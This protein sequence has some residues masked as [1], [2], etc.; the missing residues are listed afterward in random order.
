MRIYLWI[1]LI[2]LNLC[3][4]FPV[5]AQGNSVADSKPTDTSEITN[6]EEQASP[7]KPVRLSGSVPR[8]RITQDAQRS[9]ELMTEHLPK[10]S[11]LWL[12]AGSESFLSVWQRDR[13]GN[14]KGALLI[15]HAEG[16]S[17][18]WP[19]TTLRLHNT[20]PDHGWMTLAISLPTPDVQK[21]PARTLPVKIRARPLEAEVSNAGKGEIKPQAELITEST[22]HTA[23]GSVSTPIPAPDRK[24]STAVMIEKRLEAA[25][26]FLHKKGHF[27]IIILGGGSNAIYAQQFI[28]S[29]TPKIDNPKL[30]ATIQK[31]IRALIILNGL[32][33][34][35]DM[36]REFQQWFNDP[37]I[38]VLDIFTKTNQRSVLAS[39]QRK[40]LARLKKLKLYK[41]VGLHEMSFS[42]SWK[43]NAMSRRILGFLENNAAG[44]EIQSPRF[45]QNNK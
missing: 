2:Y 25:V 8:A 10:D 5:L 19:H 12:K 27:N 42:G 45:R 36:D 21:I 41:Q 15:I 39:R 6:T 24:E 9:V 11:I 38:P 18:Y 17:P 4:L 30:N 1:F 40:Q 23:T 7:Q 3:P 37:D 29:I 33:K 20:L 14:S 16:E 13:S 43:N 34:L 44:V 26:H 28:D 22:K 31:P 35:P 32:S